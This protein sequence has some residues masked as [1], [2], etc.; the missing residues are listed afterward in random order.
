MPGKKE[1]DLERKK[2]NEIVIH[3][4]IVSPDEVQSLGVI[5]IPA[6]RGSNAEKLQTS[7]ICGWNLE[8]RIM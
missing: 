1:G 2:W 5:Q 7:V 6:V 4:D 3:A 8:A